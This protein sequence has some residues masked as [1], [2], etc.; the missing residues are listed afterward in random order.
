MALSRHSKGP[1][2]S[3]SLREEK[4]VK[5]C[6]GSS[7]LRS[8]LQDKMQSD[9][10]IREEPPVRES[11]EGTGRV[12]RLTEYDGQREG[13]LGGSIADSCMVQFCLARPLGNSGTRLP[14][15][16][17]PVCQHSCCGLSRL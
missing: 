10:V 17:S 9:R 13:K 15:K 1:K 6:V 14:V 2:G 3:C 5:E 4:L 7:P 11:G 12:E 16:G 8:R